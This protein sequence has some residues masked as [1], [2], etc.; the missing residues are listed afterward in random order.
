MGAYSE[1]VPDGSSSAP[2]RKTATSN[3]YAI[4]IPLEFSNQPEDAELVDQLRKLIAQE[5][6]LAVQS[7]YTMRT[8]LRQNCEKRAQEIAARRRPLCV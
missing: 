3:G 5:D 6:A 8:R 1:A 4:S 7:R 2:S